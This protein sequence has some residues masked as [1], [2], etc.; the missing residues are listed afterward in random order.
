MVVFS[1]FI[2]K[3]KSKFG[4]F[5]VTIA[6]VLYIYGLL[7]PLLAIFFMLML[8]QAIVGLNFM[9]TFLFIISCILWLFIFWHG[10]IRYIADFYKIRIKN[11]FVSNVISIFLLCFILYIG[12]FISLDTLSANVF[13]PDKATNI[14]I[15]ILLKKGKIDQTQ[16]ENLLMEYDKTKL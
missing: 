6:Q 12:N 11:S 8:E 13:N 9:T 5:F 1:Y 3:N 4:L 16:A 10:L 2:D 7:I 15:Q 14:I